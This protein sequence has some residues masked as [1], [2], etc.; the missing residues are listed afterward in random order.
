M[1]ES[2]KREEFL[3][4]SLFGVIATLIPFQETRAL[5]LITT[6][7]AYDLGEYQ[8]AKELARQAKI[9]FYKKEYTIAKDLYLEC[10]RLAPTMIQYYDG[11]QNVFAVLKKNIHT[12]ELYKNGLEANP[13]AVAFYDRLARALVR[14]ELGNKSLLNQ[15]HELFG[16]TVLLDKAISLYNQ[17]LQ[18]DPSKAYLK[19]GLSK[20]EYLKSINANTVYAHDNSILKADKRRH[21]IQYKNRYDTF[22]DTELNE[23]IVNMDFKNRNELFDTIDI[24]FRQKSIINEKKGIHR[25]LSHRFYDNKDYLNALKHIKAMYDL[26]KEDPY[27]MKSLAMMY[28]KQKDYN[29]LVNLK[30]EWAQ[31]K[32]SF[33]SRLGLIKTLGVAFQKTNDKEFL[34]EA[35]ALS[36]KLL[37]EE[38]ILTNDDF[39]FELNLRLAKLYC[40]DQQ[41]LEAIKIY[42]GYLGNHDLSPSKKHKLSIGY[43][44]ATRKSGNIN[45]AKKLLKLALRQENET[46]SLDE[47]SIYSMTKKIKKGSRLM[48]E[49]ELYELYEDE[50]NNQSKEKTIE[51]ILLHNPNDEFI[52]SK[53]KGN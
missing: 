46:K 33:W 15:V 29:N 39:S 42:K 16:E 17:A 6:R 48:F 43:I 41:F 21:R 35:I 25:I 7:K 8:T 26:D 38:E 44:K 14:V 11:L 4:M 37:S 3:R 50:G 45:K 27:V 2:M 12:V 36:L 47:G 53:S 20:V 52:K 32:K 19:K 1:K 5:S 13:E 31:T 34:N 10:V 49:Y 22:S 30:R 40:D 23:K 9:A 18:I 28:S 24:N 51:R